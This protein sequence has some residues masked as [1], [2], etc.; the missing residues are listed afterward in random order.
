M[1]D[2]P[3]PGLEPVSPTLAGGFLT[4]A[5]RGKSPAPSFKKVLPALYVLPSTSDKQQP[6]NTNS[7]LHSARTVGVWWLTS[8]QRQHNVS[9]NK[10]FLL[11]G[12]AAQL[13]AIIYNNSTGNTM[14]V[15]PHSHCDFSFRAFWEGSK[16]RVPEELCSVLQKGPCHL[17]S[18]L[19]MNGSA[20]GGGQWSECII[21]NNHK[22]FTTDFKG[23]YSNH[24]KLWNVSTKEHSLDFWKGCC[25]SV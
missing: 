23:I 5:P 12:T 19:F 24:S 16:S 7:Y 3:G 10:L 14:S 20:L 8:S 15:W 21:S 22:A 2:L 13:P 1:W 17:P 9:E 18:P 6:T 4:T 11:V 25:S